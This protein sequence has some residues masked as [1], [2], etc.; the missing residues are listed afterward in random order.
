[1]KQS[2]TPAFTPEMEEKAYSKVTRRMMPLLFV[3]FVVEYIARVN[4][5]YARLQMQADLNLSET[6]YGIAAGMFFIGYFL[7]EVPANLLMQKIGAKYWLSTLMILSGFFCAAVMF[8]YSP[9]SF[10]ILRFLLGIVESG[11]FPG[12]ILFLTFWYPDRHRAKVTSLFMTG[13]PLSGVV[14]G[15]ISG[16]I[17]TRMANIGG[18]KGWQWLFVIE[19]LMAAVG[20]IAVM[21]VLSNGPRQSHWLNDT[22]KEL[23]ANSVAADMAKRAHSHKHRAVDAFKS[24]LVWLWCVVYFGLVMATYGVQFWLPQIIKDT[25]TRNDFYVSLISIIPWTI[26]AITMVIVGHHSDKTGERR[27][28]IAISGIIAAAAF[29]ISATPGISGVVSLIAITIATAGV[30]ST[31]ATFWALPTAFLAGTAA[32]AGIAWINSLGNLSGYVSPTLVAFLRTSTGGMA[33]PLFML[34]GCCVV[35]SVLVVLFGK[36]EKA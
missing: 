1:M 32:A 17:M 11:F 5:G 14:G 28:H 19:G 22:E 26:G 29:M 10:Y 31:L 8:S 16:W 25:L 34:A 7:F 15:L 27:W 36:K 2:V 13:V 18:L 30:M 24:P 9:Y 33:V 20:G 3:C 21:T 4:V 23:M 6:V 35:A 12:V